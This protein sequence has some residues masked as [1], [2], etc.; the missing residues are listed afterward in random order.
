MNRSDQKAVWILA[1]AFALTLVAAML[2]APPLFQFGYEPVSPGP[3]PMERILRTEINQAD[4]EDFC[5]LPGIGPQKAKA[6]LQYREEHGDFEN[7]D[8]LAQV[9]GI[10]Q[11]LLETLRPYLYLE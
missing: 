11:E 3:V 2:F 5:L 8:D 1:V 6:I 4:E 9:P 10:A 7:V